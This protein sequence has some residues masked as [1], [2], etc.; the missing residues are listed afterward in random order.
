MATAPTPKRPGRAGRLLFAA[1]FVALPTLAALALAALWAW[2]FRAEGHWKAWHAAYRSGARAGSAARTGL[3][4][5]TAEAESA[6]G[7]LGVTLERSR[8]RFGPMSAAAVARRP[9]YWLTGWHA[10]RVE[11]QAVPF[12]NCMAPPS[13]TSPF[14]RDG[15]ELGM[16]RTCHGTAFATGMTPDPYGTGDFE[17]RA[18]AQ[19]V[20]PIWLWM[21]PLAAPIVWWA[22]CP[23]GRFVP[24]LT[25]RRV[26]GALVALALALAALAALGRAS[27][28]DRALDAL[29]DFAS[30]GYGPDPDGSGRP[31]LDSVDLGRRDGGPTDA[32][33]PAIRA[34]LA[35]F[36]HV[37]SLVVGGAM[38]P[39]GIAAVLG[40]A[41]NV[42][43]LDL[44]MTAADDATL[45]AL[46]AARRL[47]VLGLR[48]TRVTD[49]GLAHLHGLPAL[50][51]LN[52]GKLPITAAGLAHLH[53]LPRLR[54]LTFYPSPHEARVG[55]PAP[56]A[57]TAALRAL[58]RS[59]PALE[60]IEL[61]DDTTVDRD[62]RPNSEPVDTESAPG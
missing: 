18:V 27:S 62:L 47:R 14:G 24:R 40:S 36:P 30:W 21:L 61:P 22:W 5:I 50:E 17:A 1:G 59:L 29:G 16:F 20:A 28:S 51:E 37:R 44:D 13:P 57:P 23:P 52:L 53:G 11:A 10:V 35:H 38:S 8:R 4:S 3:E 56:L 49:A 55:P 42:E 60:S 2:S 46:R 6:R 19:L 32:D 12:A 9:G 34:A 25:V 33:V 45:A 41:P 31:V 48:H 39:T 26:Q 54:T 58:A 7:V 43:E 15:D